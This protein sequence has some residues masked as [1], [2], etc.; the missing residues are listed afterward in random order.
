[1]RDPAGTKTPTEL[2]GHPVGKEENGGGAGCGGGQW[3]GANGDVST[4][5]MLMKGG[6]DGEKV[7]GGGGSAGPAKNKG[8]SG[9]G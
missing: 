9:N 6:L 4:T 5:E 2:N 3:N 7:N 8:Q 1:M